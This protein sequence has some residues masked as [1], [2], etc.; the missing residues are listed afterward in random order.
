MASDAMQLKDVFSSRALFGFNFNF[1]THH[2][3]NNTDY[4]FT[5]GAEPYSVHY[6]Y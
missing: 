1:L 6:F 5:H 3:P 4:F 2:T